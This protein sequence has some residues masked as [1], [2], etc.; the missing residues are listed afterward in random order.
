MH[1]RCNGQRVGTVPFGFDLAT[2]GTTLIENPTEQ[3]VVADIRRMRAEGATL[4]RIAVALTDRRV[5]TK[6]GNKVWTHQTI[7]RIVKR[8][9]PGKA[10]R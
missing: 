10:P 3:A 8:V 2:D 6:T 4:K 5:R 1:K 7:A 9:P